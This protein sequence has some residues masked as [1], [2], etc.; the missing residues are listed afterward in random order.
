MRG[1]EA[2]ET[3]RRVALQEAQEPGQERVP[4][5]RGWT[6][7]CCELQGPWVLLTVQ[8][9]SSRKIQTVFK[10]LLQSPGTCAQCSV[11]AGWEGVWGREDAGVC[12]A[13][14]PCCPPETVTALLIG[15]T[16]IQDKIFFKNIFY[17]C[18]GRKINIILAGFMIKYSIFFF[19]I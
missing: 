1:E 14:S 11:A 6:K 18:S 5:S 4:R 15:C 16:P 8:M 9:L 3:V 19:W 7:L 17:D 13:G 2:K 10:V 12:A